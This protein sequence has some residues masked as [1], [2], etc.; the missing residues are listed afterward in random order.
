MLAVRIKKSPAQISQ[1]LSG[2]RTITEETARE[3]EHNAGKPKGWLDALDATIAAQQ[4]PTR[5]NL[6]GISSPPPKLNDRFADN[7]TPTPSEWA[8]IDNIRAYPPEL[9]QARMDEIAAEAE[10]WRAYR[11]QVIAEI[12]GGKS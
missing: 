9:R 4:A 10:K 2:Y 1:W 5:A 11:D 7:R 12:K 8:M 3:I 6:A